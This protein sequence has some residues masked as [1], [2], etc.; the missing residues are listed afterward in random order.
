MP[1]LRVPR[2]TVG[3]A[4]IVAALAGCAG[5]RLS[6]DTPAGIRLEGVWRLN[7]GAS[8]DPGKVIDAMR[9][10]ALKRMRRSI[11]ASAAS[12]PMTAGGQGRR[13]RRGQ[14]GGQASQGA[15]DDQQQERD[16]AAQQAAAAIA[17]PHFDP[18]RNSP[19]MHTLTAILGRSDFLTLHQAPDQMVFDYGT[20]V[21]RY[22]PGGHSVVSS[23]TGVA[24]QNSG[25]KS[26]AYRIDVK[27]QVGPEVTEEYGLS[28]DG[29]HLIL[30][31]QI[32]SFDLPK[33]NLTR[34][35]DTTGEV[36]P[37]TRPSNE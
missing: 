19:T 31:L 11:G 14:S 15:T 24:D 13:G 26:K 23:E 36:V 2:F 33:I 4:L 27:P 9:A 37:H 5:S 22:T 12:P 17:A 1:I 7:R 34:V 30:K 16:E 3:A 35:Y 20:T 21:R 10:E 28:P 6:P 32:G 29:K 25:W 8:D 18:L